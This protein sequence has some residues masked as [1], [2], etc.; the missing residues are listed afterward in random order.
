MKNIIIFIFLLCT[1]INLFG[2]D[3]NRNTP[4]STGNVWQDDAQLLKLSIAHHYAYDERLDGNKFILTD[5]LQAEADKVN[6]QPTLLKFAER[7]L[8][9]LYDHH[10]FTGGSFNDSW[11]LVPSYSDMWIEKIEDQYTV[12]S[13]RDGYPAQKANINRGDQLVMI[14]DQTINKAVAEFWLDLGV[15]KY[16][17]K[18]ASFAARILAAGRRNVERSLSTR[19]NNGT[20]THKLPNLYQFKTSK[21]IIET[22]LKDENFSIIINDALGNNDLIPAFD[23]AMSQ[24]KP[25]HNITID[26]RNTPSG[27]NTVIARAIMGW[28]VNKPTPYQIHILPSEKKVTGIERRWSE[29]VMPREGKYHGGEITV[30]VGRWTGSMGEGIAVGLDHIGADVQGDKMAGLLGAIYDLNLPHSNFLFK[31]PSERLLAVDGTARE[32]F[33]PSP[34]KDR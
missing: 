4:P 12:T 19:G 5:K 10:A 24:A 30:L 11:A 26:L 14:G 16:N 1:H 8:M 21:P 15:T 22:N 28:F 6:S 23:K 7:A 25:N 29:F 2:Q 27:G 18:Q 20:I 17:N 9:L 31:I 33:N 13:I 32:D 3:N 34:I